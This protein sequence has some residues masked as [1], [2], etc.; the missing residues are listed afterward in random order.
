M[1]EGNRKRSLV[2]DTAADHPS[3][4]VKDIDGKGPSGLKGGFAG[5]GMTIGRVRVDNYR[6]WISL[7][8]IH[9]DGPG[10]NRS[11]VQ[12]DLPDAEIGKGST[13]LI[14]RV[15]IALRHD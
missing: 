9:L 5:K 12:I 7:V 8:V 4:H 14:D 3:L 1:R 6:R 15:R 2:G 11:S 13:G 10:V